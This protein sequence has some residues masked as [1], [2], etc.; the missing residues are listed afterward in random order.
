MTLLRLQYSKSNDEFQICTVLGDFNS[1]YDI[2]YKLEGSAKVANIKVYDVGSGVLLDMK[3][4]SQYNRS[5]CQRL[6]SCEN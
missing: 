5:V 3:K 6:N 2:Y 4:S 1:I